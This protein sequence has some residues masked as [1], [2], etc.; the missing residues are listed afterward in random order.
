MSFSDV[1]HEAPWVHRPDDL[2]VLEHQDFGSDR[3]TPD[4]ILFDPTAV[5]VTSRRAN[6]RLFGGALLAN[7]KRN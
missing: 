1:A 4:I 7:M 5:L 6:F 2:K 3:S